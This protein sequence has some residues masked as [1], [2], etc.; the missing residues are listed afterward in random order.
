MRCPEFGLRAND[1]SWLK[2]DLQEGPH[3]AAVSICG[4][5]GSMQ[6]LDDLGDAIARAC[7]IRITR[8]EFRFL[9]CL[10]ALV[11]R[12]ITMEARHRKVLGFKTLPL[13]NGGV[14]STG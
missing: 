11:Q 8:E 5:N 6:H 3:L 10:P 1:R 4:L 7:L 12:Q 2:V 9:F 14:A 13:E